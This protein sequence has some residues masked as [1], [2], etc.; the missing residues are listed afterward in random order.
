MIDHNEI[1]AWTSAN[2]LARAE[3][4]RT[5]ARTEWFDCGNPGG[6]TRHR[7]KSEPTCQPCRTAESAYQRANYQRKTA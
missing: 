1:R 6:A 5:R 4:A 3:Y 2:L 7:A